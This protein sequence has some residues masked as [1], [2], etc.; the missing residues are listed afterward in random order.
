VLYT[1]PWEY[2]Y[3]DD[4]QQREAAGT[5]AIVSVI[6]A[7]LAFD[8][9]D[10]IGE[11]RLHQL[12]QHC[13]AAAMHAWG[14]HPKIMILGPNPLTVP[15]LGILSLVLDNGELHHN[16]AVRLLNDLFGIQVRGGC[17][18]AG[19]YGHDLLQIGKTQSKTIRTE[20]D[21]GNYTAKPG[22]IRVSF[23]PA[24]APE[25]LAVLLDAVPHIADHWRDY[26]NDYV[27]NQ[28]T[29]EWRHRHDVPPRSELQM[30]LPDVLARM[31]NR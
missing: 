27:L 14:S 2:R 20:L 18:C 17:M 9:K 19:T 26:A 8:L 6:R 30:R 31:T 7:G 29:A 21:D 1:S 12:E 4:L 22:W 11:A 10:A 3:V 15:R 28:D 13:V 16:L 25:D 5:L 24:V 23:G